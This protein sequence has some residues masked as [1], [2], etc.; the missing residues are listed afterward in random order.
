RSHAGNRRLLDSDGES[1]ILLDYK[2]DQIVTTEVGQTPADV[3]RERYATQLNL[4]QEALEAILHIRISR[5]VIYAF[6]L[7]ETID[8]V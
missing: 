7:G 2:S 1:Y 3:L 5:K 4:Y 8:L 6:A